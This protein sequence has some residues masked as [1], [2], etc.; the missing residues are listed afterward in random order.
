MDPMFCNFEIP[1]INI[2]AS[3][4]LHGENFSTFPPGADPKLE[5]NLVES[6]LTQMAS[7]P[8]IPFH[9][10]PTIVPPGLPSPDCP[11]EVLPFHSSFGLHFPNPQRTT[12]SNAEASSSIA[13]QMP[14]APTWGAEIVGMPLMIPPLAIQGAETQSCL[15]KGC[16]VTPVGQY[17]KSHERRKRC[18]DYPCTKLDKGGGHCIAHGG[19]KRCKHEGCDNLNVGGGLCIRHGGGRRCTSPGCEKAAAGGGSCISHGGGRRCSVDGCDKLDKGGGLCRAHGGARRCQVDGCGKLDKGG[20]LCLAHGGGR[21]CMQDGCTKLDVGGGHCYAHGGGKR[22]QEGLCHKSDAGGGFC[23]SHG[24]GR[25]CREETC[26]GI[27]ARNGYCR[28]HLAHQPCRHSECPA[29]AEVTDGKF[30]TKHKEIPHC[31]MKTC[32]RL[33]ESQAMKYCVE[34]VHSDEENYFCPLDRC[35]NTGAAGRYCRA[36]GCGR[37]GR[38]TLHRKSS[39]VAAL[40][41]PNAKAQCTDADA[42]GCHGPPKTM[43]AECRNGN[44]HGPKETQACG[45][46]PAEPS[47]ADAARWLC[48]L[49]NCI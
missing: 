46:D 12:P 3:S 35:C 44:G 36:H 17:C 6:L 4:L 49:R 11:N 34:H 43:G 28:Q 18:Q 31:Q 9:P 45:L 2:I 37:F 16:K 23:V 8:T 7:F 1:P 22:C 26:A 24:G 10:S 48:E 13:S 27:Q 19:G 29:T 15:Q 38:K 30:C 39:A 5:N 14:L 41:E 32:A 25:R 40:G 20:G 21:Q 47:E 42:T 33:L